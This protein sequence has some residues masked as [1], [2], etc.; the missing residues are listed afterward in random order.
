LDKLS[1][2]SGCLI[3][4]HGNVVK[5][6]IIKGEWRFSDGEKIC[7]ITKLGIKK[8]SITIRIGFKFPL[9]A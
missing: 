4:V 7:L 5:N 2:K 3:I 6:P 8:L 1:A 9:S